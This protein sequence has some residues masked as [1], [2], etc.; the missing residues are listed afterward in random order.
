MGDM[1][2][3]DRAARFRAEFHEELQD[4]VIT[5][6]PKILLKSQ[7]FSQDIDG[8]LRLYVGLE[9]NGIRMEMMC[10]DNVFFDPDE[11]EE[12]LIE[13]MTELYEMSEDTARRRLKKAG[14]IDG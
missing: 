11:P 2:R 6:N 10:D 12:D 4:H 1:A 8:Y 13:R 5:D 14:L 3:M 7:A 9:V